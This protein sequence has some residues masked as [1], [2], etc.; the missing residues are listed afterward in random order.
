VAHHRIFRFVRRLANGLICINLF[1]L[2]G[3]V[4]MPF[5]TAYQSEYSLLRTPWIVYSLNIISLW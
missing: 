4:L 3:I 2:L 1:F 5:T